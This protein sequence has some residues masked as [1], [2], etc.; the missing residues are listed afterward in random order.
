M[1]K[2][3]TENARRIVAIADL[4]GNLHYNDYDQTLAQSLNLSIPCARLVVAGVVT[5]VADTNDGINDA[6]VDEVEQLAARAVAYATDRYGRGWWNDA[7]ATLALPT[8][9][10]PV[11][12]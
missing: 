7:A 1:T 12:A 9:R 11:N 8:V 2:R 10:E 6:A 3:Q 4:L 5:G